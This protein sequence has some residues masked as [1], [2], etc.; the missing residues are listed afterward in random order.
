MALKAGHRFVLLRQS[1]PPLPPIALFSGPGRVCQLMQPGPHTGMG[2]GQS[3][4]ASEG[5][6][7][8]TNVFCLQ[9]SS[10]GAVFIGCG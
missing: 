4:A 8:P 7:T 1:P 2:R 9:T 10:Q 5:I 3:E 6:Q